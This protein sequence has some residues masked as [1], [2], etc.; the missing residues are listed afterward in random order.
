[1]AFLSAG[2]L[3]FIVKAAGPNRPS[4]D[5]ERHHFIVDNRS[6][7]SYAEAVARAKSLSKQTPGNRY[8]VVTMKAGFL[9][10]EPKTEERSY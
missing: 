3:Y 8:Y 9:T 10:H 5:G 7:Y 1:M 4:K 6:W 2:N